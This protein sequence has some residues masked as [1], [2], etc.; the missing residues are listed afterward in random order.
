MSNHLPKAF[1]NFHFFLFLG[2]TGQ[3]A[4][5]GDFGGPSESGVVILP[6]PPKTPLNAIKNENNPCLALSKNFPL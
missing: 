3:D 5:A 2:E 6:S 1:I 4:G